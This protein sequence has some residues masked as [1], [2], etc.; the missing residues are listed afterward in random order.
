MNIPAQLV[1]GSHI[2]NKLLDEE[3]NKFKFYQ[4]YNNLN[5]E[6]W[7]GDNYFYD[8]EDLLEFW[9][10][11]NLKDING[12]VYVRDFENLTRV[13]EKYWK[14]LSLNGSQLKIYWC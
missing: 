8:E 13:E 3:K 4:N 14:S 9:G 11:N 5:K 2:F 7:F 6:K 10:V 1:I 12:S